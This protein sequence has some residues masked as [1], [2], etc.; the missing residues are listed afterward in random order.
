MKYLT[1]FSYISHAEV[2]HQKFQVMLNITS[3]KN[4]VLQIPQIPLDS[5]PKCIFDLVT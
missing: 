4:Y 3:K 2:N 1:L 5:A